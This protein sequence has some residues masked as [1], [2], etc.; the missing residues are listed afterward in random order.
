MFGP[1][2]GIAVY[3]FVSVLVLWVIWVGLAKTNPYT[4]FDTKRNAD[5][6]KGLGWLMKGLLGAVIFG[7]L[8][9]LLWK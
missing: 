9:K 7:G 3:A 4:L 6:Q 2:S 1:Q 5:V 8:S